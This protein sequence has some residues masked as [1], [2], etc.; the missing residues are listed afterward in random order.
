M[1][2]R[3]RLARWWAIWL[4]VV[5]GEIAFAAEEPRVRVTWVDEPPLLDGR[6]DDA[7]WRDAPVIDRFIQAQPDEGL[8]ATERTEV[9]IV[10]DGETLYFGVRL[11]D[12]EI[13]RLVLNRGKRD[14]RLLWDD[15]FNIVID[16]F[17][18]H[19]NGY[20]LQIN[21]AGVRRDALLESANFDD[22]WDGIWHAEARI[23]E[24]GWTLEVA[25][26]F[27]SFGFDPDGDVWGLNMV[28]GL[29]RN[30]ESARWA[31]ATKDRMDVNLCCA[32]VLEGLTGISQGLGLDLVPGLAVRRR[33]RPAKP[34]VGQTKKHD[35]IFD[36]TLD[37]FYR[38]TPG[39]TGSLSVNTDFGD[40][41]ADEQ[42][43]N[44]DRF[45]LF[46]PE[47]RDFFL[48]DA[49]LFD[50]GGLSSLFNTDSNG[51]P[52]FSRSIGLQDDIEVAGKL[53]G[54]QGPWNI[55][56][57]DAQLNGD[58][59]NLFVGR[60]SRNLFGESRAGVIV[61]NGDP[62]STN[63][64]TLIGTD[65]LYSNSDFR[66]TNRVF[67][68]NLWFQNSFT[69]RE[70]G[71][72]AAWGAELRYPNDRHNWFVRYK[73]LQG[74]FEPALGFV[75]RSDIRRYEG[76]YRFRQWYTGWIRTIDNR[77][78]GTLVTDRRNAVES[79][80]AEVTP[81]EVK[82]GVGD[83]IAAVY[84]YRFESRLVAEPFVSGTFLPAGRY[85]FSQGS[86]TLESSFNRPLHALVEARGGQFF[87]GQRAGF[88]AILDWRPS[89]HYY[90]GLEYEQDAFW[91]DL[92]TALPP[93]AIP[94]TG[95]VWV[96][97]ARLRMDVN[98]TKDVSWSTFAQYDNQSD[99]IG[100]NSRLRWIVEDGREIFV[101]LNQGLHAVNNR[102][103]RG[104]TEAIFK[105]GWT[106]RF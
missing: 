22:D 40:T 1:T 10:T 15:R 9:R 80:L 68:A 85:H 43:V 72:E 38:M 27:K 91:M 6:L 60:I 11:H 14:D 21:A 64:S 54:R 88:R 34:A 86:L 55:G 12:S 90:L 67:D 96:R 33:D 20:F 23:D 78:A 95:K 24:T 52:F 57:L 42:L 2:H 66:G 5:C 81:F 61:T 32:G 71:A 45:A 16:T 84:T 30:G 73:E 100:I 58:S 13:D 7:A 89:W 99:Q 8:P 69:E 3:L 56:L 50:F 104:E 75:N 44:L 62:N 17:H 94:H 63:D 47:K 36:P 102:V 93:P 106:F 39:L 49:L 26:P 35:T 41:E 87:N 77:I 82:N 74:D 103:I 18:D 53:T 19:R 4:A 46:F 97:I 92:L 51:L 25:L 83:R 37:A 65:F 76:S 28:R 79:G 70:K 105:V 59:D 31:D 48:R 29:R 101:V 98:F